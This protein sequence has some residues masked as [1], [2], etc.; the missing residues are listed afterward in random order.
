MLR[1][2]H[3]VVVKLLGGGD[4]Q[5]CVVLALNFEKIVRFKLL[6]SGI[7]SLES[8]GRTIKEIRKH[9]S[10]TNKLYA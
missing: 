6:D 4:I 5:G 7:V 9:L 10:W 3:V 1:G 2:S 8:N